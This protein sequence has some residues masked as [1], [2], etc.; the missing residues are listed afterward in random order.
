MHIKDASTVSDTV[1][2]PAGPINLAGII[3]ILYRC[4]FKNIK[5]YLKKYFLINAAL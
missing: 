3:F 5:N 2:L 4:V 1:L